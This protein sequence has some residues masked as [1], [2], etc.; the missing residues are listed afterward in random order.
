MGDELQRQLFGIEDL[1]SNDVGQR[2]LGGRNQV[3]VR[4]AFTADLEQIFLEFRQ[5]TGT[6][7]RRRLYE[8]RRVGLFIA[9]IAGVQ[10][11]HELRQG[12]MQAGNRPA[13][14]GEASA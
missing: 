8:I 13:H 9:V 4:F 11:D 5:L 10:V 6:L 7:K 12:A 2:H 1:A 3:E 14:Q